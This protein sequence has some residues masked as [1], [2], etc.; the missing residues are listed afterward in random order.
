MK[1]IAEAL[2]FEFRYKGC[3]CEGSPLH[4]RKTIAGYDHKLI[5]HNGRG[6]WRLI[7]GTE[8]ILQGNISNMLQS[9][10]EYEQNIESH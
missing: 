8:V 9:I 5:L 7:N 3:I 6:L 1:Q 10:T 4:Y 2:G